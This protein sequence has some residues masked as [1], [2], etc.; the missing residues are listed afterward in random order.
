MCNYVL[1]IIMTQ[2]L[3]CINALRQPKIRSGGVVTMTTP[4]QN[5]K[6]AYCI[7]RNFRGTKFSRKATK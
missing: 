5:I 7:V 1:S 3:A 2:V 6:L 4:T